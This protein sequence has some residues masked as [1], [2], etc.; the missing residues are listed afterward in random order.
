M[1]NG[2]NI[3]SNRVVWDE[4][5]IAGFQGEYRFLSNF[6][7]SKVVD[8]DGIEYPTVEHAFAAHKTLD[9]DTRREI[10]LLETPGKAK[11]AGRSVEL[12]ADWEESKVNVMRNFLLSKFSDPVLSKRLKETGRA[13]LVESNH[14]HDQFWGDCT[15]DKHSST[16]GDNTLGKLLMSI[17][18]LL[19]DF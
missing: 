2:E 1:D 16:P 6:A 7:P 5:A 9:L 17:R 8:Y 4:G 19:Q 11:R 13:K 15:C 10:A 3:G 12:R 14:W 18:F